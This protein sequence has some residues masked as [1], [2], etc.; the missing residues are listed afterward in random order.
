M[1]NQGIIFVCSTN[2]LRSPYAAHLAM[3]LYPGVTAYSAGTYCGSVGREVPNRFQ[4]ASL[5]RG[6]DLS[7]HRTELVSPVLLTRA[8]LVIVLDEDSYEYLTL[9]EPLPNPPE[10]F[11]H[12]LQDLSYTSIAEP[13]LEATEIAPVLDILDRGTKRALERL[14]LRQ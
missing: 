14:V 12:F 9:V 8:P 1:G 11:V 5:A 4:V 13:A 6:I 7:E 2:L 3:K 10:R